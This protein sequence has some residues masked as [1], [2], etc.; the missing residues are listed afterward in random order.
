MDKKVLIGLV[1]VLVVVIIIFYSGGREVEEGNE[2]QIS[3][4]CFEDD[5][6][7]VEI[8]DTHE[9]RS[10]GLMFRE[11]LCSDCG[12]LFVYEQEGIYKFWMKNTLI[13]LDIIWLDSQF[14]VVHIANAV[15]CVV[16]D[17]RLYGSDSEKAQYV[18]EVNSGVSE[19]IGLVENSE[20][21][22]VYS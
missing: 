8:A 21:E 15:P 4:V 14:K 7:S 20:L 18:L 5:C 16:E 13:P 19:R 17:C 2:L 11:E 22:L 1:V 6:F 10:R 12:M 3:E 9:E